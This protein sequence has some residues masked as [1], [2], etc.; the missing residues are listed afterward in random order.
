MKL[1]TLILA[2]GLC[3]PMTWAC[4]KRQNVSGDIVFFEYKESNM[5][6]YPSLYYKVERNEEG[7]L[8]LKYTQYGQ[9]LKV[10]KAPEDIL[11]RID[12]YVQENKLWNLKNSYVNIHV[13]DGYMWDMYIKYDEGSISS[14]GSNKRPSGKLGEGLS[15]ILAYL[16]SITDDVTEADIIN[17]EPFER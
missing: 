14:G 6:S 8:L 4:N 2:F 13:L 16:H 11:Q 10:I 12:G 17:Y 5:R 7:T 15:S 9:I 1:I 3:L